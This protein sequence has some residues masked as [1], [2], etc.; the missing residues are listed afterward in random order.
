[1]VESRVYRLL[2]SVYP[3]WSSVC[4][5]TFIFPL[6]MIERQLKFF[7]SLST[8]TNT[9]CICR[10][11]CLCL[12]NSTFDAHTEALLFKTV[13]SHGLLA[14]LR[15]PYQQLLWSKCCRVLPRTIRSE[16]LQ[17][18]DSNSIQLHQHSVIKFPLEVRTLLWV[19]IKWSNVTLRGRRDNSSS[20][21]VYVTP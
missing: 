20:F 4:L 21:Q 2:F 6:L 3:R 19:S 15:A 12:N 10:S 5:M 8:S 13:D 14:R 18:G 16:S 1:M 11:G 7:F 17:P 9:Y